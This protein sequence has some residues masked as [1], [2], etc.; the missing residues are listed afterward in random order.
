[1]PLIDS[2]VSD[3]THRSHAMMRDTMLFYAAELATDD[4]VT[5]SD[6]AGTVLRQT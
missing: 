6:E 3:A 1:M 4:R 2:D 5:T